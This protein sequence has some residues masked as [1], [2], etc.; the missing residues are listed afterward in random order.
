M[1]QMPLYSFFEGRK[2]KYWLR[3]N[4]ENLIYKRK[5]N[6]LSRGRKDVLRVQSIPPGMQICVHGGS[7]HLHPLLWVRSSV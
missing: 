5:K 7:R 2:N 4:A 1:G 3:N 6:H